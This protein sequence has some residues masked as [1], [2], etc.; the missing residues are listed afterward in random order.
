MEDKFKRPAG[1]VPPKESP[2]MSKSRET[3]SST[4]YV[5][6]VCAGSNCC[7]HQAEDIYQALRDCLRADGGE[8]LFTLETTACLGVC[9][10]PPAISVNG[11]I[12][13]KMTPKSALA[14]VENLRKRKRS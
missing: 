14:L 9:G 13:G 11:E 7:H 4:A 8:G 1:P 6:R 12:Y 10:I 3:G 5:I 2:K